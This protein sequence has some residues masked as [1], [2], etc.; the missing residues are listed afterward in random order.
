MV[1]SLV[2]VIMMAGYGA[3]E[4]QVTLQAIK[5]ILKPGKYELPLNKIRELVDR[6]ETSPP[7]ARGVGT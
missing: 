2:M 7:L 4:S 6:Y 5:K 3:E 1:K